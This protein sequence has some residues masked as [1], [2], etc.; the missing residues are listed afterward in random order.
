MNGGRTNDV[1]LNSCPSGWSGLGANCYK[2]FIITPSPT[3]PPLTFDQAQ[4]ECESYN[5]RLA[6]PKD[7]AINDHIVGLRNA[8]NDQWAAWIGIT[9]EV[10]GDHRFLDGEQVLVYDN[11]AQN[12]P[13]EAPGEADCVRI[14]ANLVSSPQFANQWRDYPCNLPSIAYICE[15]QGCPAAPPDHPPCV[16]GICFD[17]PPF[18]NGDNCIYRCSRNC[19]GALSA[20]IV[21][22]NNG[23]WDGEVP[24]C[25]SEDRDWEDEG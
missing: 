21:T 24:V 22:C 14:E 16:E 1:L 15:L 8:G 10:E 13:D 2:A 19:T 3:T 25:E 18:N 6:Q 12:E 17:P 9:D 11:W 23:A 4:A 20:T 5:G 7:Q